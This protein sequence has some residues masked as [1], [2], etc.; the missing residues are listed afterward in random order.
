M[1]KEQLYS[2]G[3][4]IRTAAREIGCTPPHLS[5]VLSGERKSKSLTRRLMA[6]PKVT[7][8]KYAAKQLII[9]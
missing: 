6:L 2:K 7:P 8:S 3:W 4:S 5:K 1:T 9:K